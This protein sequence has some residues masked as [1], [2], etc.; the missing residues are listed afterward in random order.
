MYIVDDQK[1]HRQTDA[2]SS[3]VNNGISP[4][5]HSPIHY[6]STEEDQHQHRVKY[7]PHN[8]DNN[9]KSDKNDKKQSCQS[10]EMVDRQ[11]VLSERIK[12]IQEKVKIAKIMDDIYREVLQEEETVK[13]E[14]QQ[15]KEGGGDDGDDDE[16]TIS[17][18]STESNLEQF[19]RRSSAPS[20]LQSDGFDYETEYLP[21]GSDGEPNL[22]ASFDSMMVLPDVGLPPPSSS[23]SS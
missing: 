4:P 21:G 22:H 14:E 18:A 20:K 16:G 13:E 2:H 11:L 12:E 5:Q 17:S 19:F 6:G 7:D 1:M 10:P 3:A 9:I 15:Q 8:I 23:S